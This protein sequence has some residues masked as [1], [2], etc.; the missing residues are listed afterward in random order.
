MRNKNRKFVGKIQNQ[1][2]HEKDKS[3]PRLYTYVP[4]LCCSK[5]LMMYFSVIRACVILIRKRFLLSVF[6]YSYSF[7]IWTDLINMKLESRDSNSNQIKNKSIDFYV[8]V[9]YYRQ[10]LELRDSNSNPLQFQAKVS[11]NIDIGKS[12]ELIC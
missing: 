11:I 8:F 12:N 3:K 1:I 6:D 7:I 4:C 5:L 2:H 10:V 9:I